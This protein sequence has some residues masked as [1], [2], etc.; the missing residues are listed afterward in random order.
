MCTPLLPEDDKR[1]AL[2]CA[3]HVVCP[4]TPGDTDSASCPKWTPSLIEMPRVELARIPLVEVAGTS[5]AW[6][7]VTSC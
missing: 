1:L 6:L 5:N 7:L 4:G 2:D 3:D